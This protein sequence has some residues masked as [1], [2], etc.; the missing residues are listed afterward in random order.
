MTGR[1]LALVT[2]EHGPLARVTTRLRG[3][4]DDTDEP[5]LE[6]Q[7]AAAAQPTRFNVAAVLSPHGGTGK[8]TLTLLLANALAR[9]G[10]VRTVVVDATPDYGALAAT[11]GVDIGAPA[12]IGDLIEAAPGL[13]NPAELRPY[14]TQLASGADLLCGGPADAALSPDRI[15]DL[16]GYLAAFYE[17]A[18]VDCATG[19]ASE[20]AQHAIAR[21]D[22]TVLVTTPQLARSRAALQALQLLQHTSPVVALNRAHHSAN[23]LQDI[24]N[25]F[26]SEDDTSVGVVAIPEDPELIGAVHI[27]RFDLD[28]VAH[29][30]RCQAKQLAT[31]VAGQ[32][33]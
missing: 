9:H 2:D 24:S 17:L 13:L 15:A 30:T 3:R 4:R 20:L 33:R 7:I 6:E 22:Q 19:I 21:A 27:D 8:T 26:T 28:A 1:P 29:I 16:L 32:L 18:L 23:A 31:L 14:M 11:G 5:A 12:T 10:N 25:Q